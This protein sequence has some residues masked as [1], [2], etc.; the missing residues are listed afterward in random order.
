MEGVH[1]QCDDA[2][3]R[4]ALEIHIHRWGVDLFIY[5]DLNSRLLA[6]MCSNNTYFI[7]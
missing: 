5:W 3:A 1:A 4:R 2:R 7:E 6:V